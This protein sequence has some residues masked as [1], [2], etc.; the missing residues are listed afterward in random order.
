M[1]GRGVAMSCDPCSV[2]PTA[3]HVL[4]LTAQLD[5]AATSIKHNLQRLIALEQAMRPRAGQSCC[6]NLRRLIQAQ[7]SASTSPLP[8]ACPPKSANGCVPL[9]AFQRKRLPDTQ[10]HPGSALQRKSGRVQAPCPLHAVYLNPQVFRY[11]VRNFC[12][13]DAAV[14]HLP[15]SCCPYPRCSQSLNPAELRA[16]L[17]T[18]TRVPA[19]SSKR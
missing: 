19:T 6:C 1:D 2:C 9:R 13:I 14:V 10:S 5:L 4:A 18:H 16:L 15:V 3:G 11:L 12:S 7:V 17:H 8:P